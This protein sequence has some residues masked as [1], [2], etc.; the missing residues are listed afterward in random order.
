MGRAV[1]RGRRQA[2]SRRVSAVPM[3]ENHAKLCPSPEW[4][5]YLQKTSCPRCARVSSSAADARDRS[6]PGAS[7]DGFGTGSSSWSPSSSRRRPWR[8]SRAVRRHQRR[9]A[10]GRCHRACHRGRLI[11]LGRLLHDAAPCSDS[12]AAEPAVRRGAAR[13]APRRHVDRLGQPAQHRSARLPLG[14]IYNPVDP[15]TL[16]T[17]LQTVGFGAITVSV[18]YGFT[19]R[20][21]K[22]DPERD[23]IWD[24]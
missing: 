22:P 12:G 23:G 3:N 2:L 17:R 18:D 24:H 13:A 16:L 8:R 21:R 5:A 15:A 7:T 19:F 9:G 11:R 10:A 1:R 4:A 6:G 14:D 20:A